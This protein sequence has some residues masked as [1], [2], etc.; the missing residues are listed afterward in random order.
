MSVIARALPLAVLEEIRSSSK[1][2][3]LAVCA[4]AKMTDLDE[5][6]LLAQVLRNAMSAYSEQL[7]HLHCFGT[8]FECAT[9]AKA[10]ETAQACGEWKQ[11]QRDVDAAWRIS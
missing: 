8:E 11:W 10:T 5:V 3:G 1:I 2:D 4:I 9:C 6:K 7:T